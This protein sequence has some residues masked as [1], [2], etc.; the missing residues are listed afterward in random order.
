MTNVVALIL[1]LVI[2][3]AIGTDFAIND[4]LATDFMAR[5]FLALVEWV[6]F[7]R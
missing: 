5:K 7:W 1:G 2:A 3:A 6:A 4:G